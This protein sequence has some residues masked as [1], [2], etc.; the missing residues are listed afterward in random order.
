MTEV[1]M[2]NTQIQM[3]KLTEL[4]HSDAKKVC[5]GSDTV[6]GKVKWA[7]APVAGPEIYSDTVTGKVK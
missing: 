1:S 3:K 2:K 7:P 5:G 6:N 4:N